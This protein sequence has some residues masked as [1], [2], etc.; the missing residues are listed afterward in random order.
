M[1][2]RGLSVL[3]AIGLLGCGENTAKT[4]APADSAATAATGDGARAAATGAVGATGAAKPTGAGAGWAGGAAGTPTGNVTGTSA[5]TAGATATGEDPIF[6]SL[7][8]LPQKPDTKPSETV[9]DAGGVFVGLP[10]GWKTSDTNTIDPTLGYSAGL[11]GC[12]M[13]DPPKTSAAA[14]TDSHPRLCAVQVNTPPA[15]SGRTTTTLEL[16]GFYLNFD[17]ATWS[18]WA[19]GTVGDGLKA[20]LSKGTLGSKEA[21][22]AFIEVP[23]KKSILIVARWTNDEEKEAVFEMVRGVGSCT[24]SADKR[25]CTP[26]KPYR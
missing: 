8:G 23:G 19:D 25:K 1:W 10:A 15:L 6:A 9:R 24:F 18:P 21:F 5:S 17:K 7:K 2:V 14:R 20:K 16:Y 12:L 4:S 22:A 3:I 11:G 26:D 13:F